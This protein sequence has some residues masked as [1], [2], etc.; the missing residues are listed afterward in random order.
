MRILEGLEI[1][2]RT[3]ITIIATIMIIS[4]NFADVFTSNLVIESGT[5][6]TTKF[7]LSQYTNHPRIRVDN[8]SEFLSAGFEGAGT[9]ENPY[10][11]SNINITSQSDPIIISDTNAH[12]IIRNSWFSSMGHGIYLFQVGNATLENCIITAENFGIYL[13]NCRN[14][15]ID[16]MEMRSGSAGIYAGGLDNSIIENSTMHHN[17][18]GIQIA[19]GEFIEIS[20][21]KVYSNRDSGIRLE[22]L[23]ANVSVE[24]CRVGWNRARTNGIFGPE[25]NADDEGEDNLWNGNRWSDYDGE[26]PSYAISLVSEDQNP[27][28]LLDGYLPTVSGLDDIRYNEGETGYSIHWNSSDEYMSYFE[29]WLDGEILRS[30][31]WYGGK[32]FVDLNETPI[33]SHNYTAVFIDAS[34]N[35]V[36]DE[37]WVSVLLSIFGGEGTILVLYASVLSVGLV[38]LMLLILKRM[39]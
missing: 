14:I 29:V 38:V 19:E 36:A 35:R 1:R 25:N 27:I 11:I 21:C 16:R 18:N 24:G 26:R 8:D 10:V 2:R 20:E 7:S 30:G 5:R 31:D 22:Q 17:D 13:L 4:L 32:L 37:T 34:G 39:R 3:L 12:F 33:G 23:A 15:S 9:P 28:L 6:K